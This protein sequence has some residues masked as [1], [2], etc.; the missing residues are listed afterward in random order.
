M[1]EKI[2]LQEAVKRSV[3][4]EK[5]A[6]DF[7]ALGAK[8]MKNVEAKKTFELLAREERDHAKQ[9]FD[10]Y[11]GSDLP[12]FE[13]FI[14]SDPVKEGEWLTDMEKALISDFNERKAME[15]AMQKEQNLEKSLREMAAKIEDPQVKAVYEANAK[16]THQHYQ[17]IESEYA[18]LMGMVHET[19][20]D[21]YVRE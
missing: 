19:D 15:L 13:T 18:R 8:N 6:M 14:N 7:Y 16:S 10:V 11:E 21:T 9:F 4:T 5:N 1:A 20:I 3:Q 17:L 2:N 12:D